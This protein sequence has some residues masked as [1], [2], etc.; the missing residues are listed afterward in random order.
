MMTNFTNRI[1]KKETGVL[2][3]LIGH[4]GSKPLLGSYQVW[5]VRTIG[6]DSALKKTE[7][8]TGLI[9]DLVLESKPEPVLKLGRSFRT[10]IRSF[11]NVFFFGKLEY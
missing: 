5:P 8:E 2:R 1:E 6:F 9:L 7:S 3:T 10:R 11:E 4:I